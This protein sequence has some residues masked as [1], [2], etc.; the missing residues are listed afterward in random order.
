MRIKEVHRNLGVTVE[1]SDV[2]DWFKKRID[3]V[4]KDSITDNLKDPRKV[5]LEED[6]EML[7]NE[8]VLKKKR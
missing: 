7:L 2:K 1:E 3:E 8:R 6:E 4:L 5:S